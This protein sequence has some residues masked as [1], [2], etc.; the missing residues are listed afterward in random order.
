MLPE[1]RRDGLLVHEVDGEMVVYDRDRHR[2]HRLNQTAALVWSN[3][4]GTTSVAEIAAQ[5]A[6]E[7]ELPVDEDVV[8]LALDRLERTNLLRRPVTRPADAKHLS[9]RQVM[10]KLAWVG[11][12][13]LLL[14][15]VSSITSPTPAMANSGPPPQPPSTL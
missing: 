12:A 4:D 5:L 8:W 3:C 2:A 6:T 15:V 10:E 9:R 1:A 13:S 7:L 11:A 14:P